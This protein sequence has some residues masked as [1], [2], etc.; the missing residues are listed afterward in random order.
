MNK[1][2]Q[3]VFLTAN[4]KTFTINIDNPLEPIDTVNVKSTMDTIIS[5]NIINS[6]NGELV[7]IKGAYLVT[8]TIE[9]IQLD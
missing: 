7:G 8:K 5:S 1:K 9:E 2:L 6:S 4:N 3:L